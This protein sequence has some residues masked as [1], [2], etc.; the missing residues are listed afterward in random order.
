[1]YIAMNQNTIFF[2][3]SKFIFYIIL[4]SIWFASCRK[5][6]VTAPFLISK[7]ANAYSGTPVMKYFNLLCTITKSTP[8]FFPPQA[9][10]AYGYVGITNYEAVVNGTENA[11][12]LGGQLNGLSITDLPQKTAGLQYNWAISSNTA[13]ADIIRK[14]FA[15]N[16]TPANSFSIDSM[17]SVNLAALST[18][19]DVDII[20][21][22]VQFG[23]DVSAAIYK[24]SKTDGGHESYLDPFQLPYNLPVDSFCWVPTSAVLHPISPNWG[25]NRPFML[26]NITN[27][28]PS[29]PLSFSIE[30]TSAFYKEAISV[31]NQ[32]Q[33]NTAEQAEIAKYWSDDPFST[34]TPTGH[35]FNILAQL[36]EE[37]RATLEKTSV[38]FAKM[39]IA[40]NDAFIS[41]WK[42]KYK[43]VLIRPVSYI[44]NYI[45]PSFRTV[46]GTPPFPAYTSGHSCEMGAGSRIFTN[47]FTDGSGN[48]QFTDYS[49]LRYGFQP[50][51]FTN[52][53]EM[54]NECAASRFYGGLHYPMDNNRG[55]QV[56][57][58]VGDNVNNQINW[59]KNIR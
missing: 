49:Q 27:T 23:K 25:N 37:N 33:N 22:S 31:Y 38:A 32:V 40:E 13:I 34:C 41:C 59:P 2:K 5:D 45:A 19:E 15:I 47:L 24:Y 9:A 58:A 43:Y 12:S 50:R 20:N 54:A 10:R 55:L 56:G 14:M 57:R 28:Q 4:F 21:R 3:K 52:F 36:L 48:Y 7:P 11:L 6:D 26:T 18:G 8:G 35:T 53:T 39:S 44:K 16:I 30:P 17:E 42:G 51:N 29:A 1:M 46:I